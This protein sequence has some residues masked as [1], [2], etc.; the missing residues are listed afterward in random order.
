MNLVQ[1]LPKGFIV[2]SGDINLFDASGKKDL[3]N[4]GQFSMKGGD[5]VQVQNTGFGSSEKAGGK[6]RGQLRQG[7]V[8]VK[9]PIAGMG[10]RAAILRFKKEDVFQRNKYSLSAR[11][12]RISSDTGDFP[13][14]KRTSC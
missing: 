11:V 1:T 8:G 4:S 9:H 12:R 13:S 14:S 7:L 5:L 3:T 6:G 10:R 2:H